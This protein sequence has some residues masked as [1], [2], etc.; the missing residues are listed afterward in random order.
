MENRKPDMGVYP[1]GTNT[2]P[3]SRLA[4]IIQY[5]DA[6]HDGYSHEYAAT[7]REVA[8]RA[9]PPEGRQD[10][11]GWIAN[12]NP[13]W[14]PWEG[15]I[16][17]ADA[18]GR[19]ICWTPSGGNELADAAL[20]VRAVNAALTHSTPVEAPTVWRDIPVTDDTLE[21]V[22]KYG[23]RCRDCAD[24]YGVCQS[25]LPCKLDE[26]H[27][28]IR[29]VLR[30]V[31]YGMAHGYLRPVAL[32]AQ[33]LLRQGTGEAHRIEHDGFEGTVQG[34]YVTREGKRGV[35]LQQVGTKV[36]HV[37]GEKWISAQLPETMAPDTY[38]GG[39]FNGVTEGEK[40]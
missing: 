26:R 22:S 1:P 9:S 24:M 6:G 23:G 7:L 25:G 30:A 13:D 11:V 31:N 27:A 29:H 39:N 14:V 16:S 28:A 18:N 36:V 40:P 8:A 15:A 3:I 20:I 32:A 17:I 35:V 33:P 38:T 37:Y 4:F 19:V 21:Y 34:H 5:F 10:G 12:D 2:D